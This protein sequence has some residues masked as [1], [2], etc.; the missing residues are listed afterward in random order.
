MHGLAFGQRAQEEREALIVVLIDLLRTRNEGFDH[1]RREFPGMHSQRGERLEQFGRMD[2]ARRERPALFDRPA[3]SMVAIGDH[4]A[5]DRLDGMTGPPADDDAAQIVLAENVPKCFRP[6][7][8]VGDGL[9]AAP[10][11]SWLRKAVDSVLEGT[12]AGGNG[13]PQHRRD[14]WVQGGD[15]ASDPGLDEALE[16][17]HFAGVEH[18]LDDFPVGGIPADEEDFGAGLDEFG[19]HGLDFQEAGGRAID[20]TVIGHRL[21]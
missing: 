19:R 8:E 7:G 1:V 2:S 12:F 4:H 16:V 3:R 6:T 13:S 18:G 17:R 21:S 20:C 5:F 14:R 11:G 10:V 15:L 9:H